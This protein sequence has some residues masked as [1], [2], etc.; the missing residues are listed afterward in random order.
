MILLTG[1][2]G[3]IGRTLTQRLLEK[4]ER[5]RIL[6]LPNDPAAGLAREMGAEV[7]VGDITDATS[8]VSAVRGVDTVY[9]M[10]AVI[11]SPDPRVFARVNVEGT[12][13]LINACAAAKV[14]HIV[15]ISSAS[16][17]YPLGNPYSRSKAEAE[18]LVSKSD[19]PHYT[20]VRPTLIY[21]NEG[22]AEFRHFVN[23]IKKWPVLFMVGN[24]R[25]KKSPVHADDLV[26]G[27][28]MVNS[29]PKT[30]GQ[31]YNFSGGETISLLEISQII[32]GLIGKRKTII[33]VPIALCRFLS[34]AMRPIGW[35]MRRH[36]LL[37]WQTIS[38]MIQDADL[39]CT[40]ARRDLGYKPRSF[41]EGLGSLKFL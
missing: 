40:P 38:G 33:S 10:A 34:Y 11:I 1:G 15:Y 13:N 20:I 39:D 37:N 19:I 14:K 31:T 3:T 24:G 36:T 12:R 8:L 26:D 22:G 25:A 28:S 6:T 30:F 29:N 27:L 2:T 16:V 5:V 17:T 18:I 7:V 41:R 4:G 32:L 23:Y 35:V 9:H 21:S